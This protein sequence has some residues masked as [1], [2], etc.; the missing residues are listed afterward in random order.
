MMKAKIL[1]TTA[2]I[3]IYSCS[4]ESDQAPFQVD[5]ESSWDKLNWL[6]TIPGKGW[7]TLKRL[8]SPT[9][10]FFDQTRRPGEF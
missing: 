1:I 3:G 10:T 8:Y 2:L 5:K 9:E 6:K 4:S 7:F